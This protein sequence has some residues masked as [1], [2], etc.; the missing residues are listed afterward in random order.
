MKERRCLLFRP[1]CEPLYSSRLSELT[2]SHELST[3]VVIDG[4]YS[5]QLAIHLY[6]SPREKSLLIELKDL[7]GE[8][9]RV[10]AQW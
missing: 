4:Y 7:P 8:R 5:E 2:A 1:L 3:T 6:V 9:G 10:S